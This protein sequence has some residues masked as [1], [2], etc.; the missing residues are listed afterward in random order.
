LVRD[1]FENAG[2]TRAF[3]IFVGF[4]SVGAILALLSLLVRKAEE[5]SLKAD[6]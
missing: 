4:V 5:V 2:T 1:V 3:Y 6:G